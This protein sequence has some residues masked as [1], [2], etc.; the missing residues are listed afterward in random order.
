[1]NLQGSVLTLLQNNISSL[2]DISPSSFSGAPASQQNRRNPKQLGSNLDIGQENLPTFLQKVPLVFVQQNPL[3]TFPQDN[4][5]TLSSQSGPNILQANSPLH[6]NLNQHQHLK[7]VDEL[8]DM[9][10]QQHLL[11]AGTI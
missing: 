9:Q 3:F 11:R 8:Q 7:Q 2:Q 10:H 4:I 6:S 5:D 1:M